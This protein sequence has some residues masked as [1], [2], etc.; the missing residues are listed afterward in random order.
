MARAR[1]IKPAF[2]L[3]TDLSEVCAFSRLAFIGMW[4]IS[5]FKG[6]IELNFKKIKAQILPYDNVDME[7]ITNN[8]EQYGFIRLYSV[9]GKRYLKILNFE[10]H[11]N[12]HKNERESGSNIPDVD[13]NDNSFN[14][15]SNNPD[16]DG[17]ALDNNGT[18][19]ADSLLLNPST[20]IPESPI[21]IPDSLI[22]DIQTK[23]KKDAPATR[24][25][26]DWTLPSEYRDYCII[27]RPDLNP[28][29]VAEVFR[30]YWIAKAGVNAKKLDWY[31]TWC[32]WVLKQEKS[33]GKANG[34]KT[35]FQQ[36]QENNKKAGDEFL[37]DFIPMEKE[38]N[39]D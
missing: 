12:P 6:C 28:D 3:N 18:T 24:L 2:F 5:D 25:P 36:V 23:P 14:N 35:K 29:D 27:K 20:L 15:L 19:R 1:N 33:N 37:N 31:A 30:N 11:Q 38:V 8:L 16:K 9:Q 26:N 4:T 13:K 32:N 10:K 22:A 7:L 34:F 39:H 17:T 21:Q